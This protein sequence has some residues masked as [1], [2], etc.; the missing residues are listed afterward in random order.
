MVYA[1][2]AAAFLGAADFLAGAAFYRQLRK[3]GTRPWRRVSLLLSRLRFL[4]W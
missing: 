2:A 3:K 4:V 1:L